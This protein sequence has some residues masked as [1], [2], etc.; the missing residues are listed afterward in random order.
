MT[1]TLS[2]RQLGL[3]S[4]STHP[5]GPADLIDRLRELKLTNVQLAL[6]PVRKAPDAWRDVKP[7][8]AEAGITIV[9][10]MFG[11]TGEDYST[12]QTVRATGGLVPDRHWPTN[13]ANAQANAALARDLGLRLVSSHAGFIP[14]DPDAP[15]YANLVDRIRQIAD[16]FAETFQGT[17]LLETGQ[18]TAD[19]L[20][21][22][23]KTVDRDNVG[24][25]FDPANMLL[26]GMGD[27]VTA[28]R[29]L[30]PHVRQVHIKDAKAPTEPDTW[31]Q[32]MAI[33]EGEVDWPSFLTVL[34]ENDF[35]GPLVIER[36]AGSDRVGDVRTAIRFIHAQI[37][38]LAHA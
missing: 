16:L 14:E 17:L 11:A 6:D 33:G 29:K 4:W 38:E 22:F 20:T 21:G 12:P 30:M 3:C 31:G 27:P 10:G 28:L 35:D 34:E 26:Y 37:E 18:E 13:W 15:T 24:V 25:N 23:L 1:T 9:A 19:T 36:E 7:Q 8:L 5:S 2:P 32:E